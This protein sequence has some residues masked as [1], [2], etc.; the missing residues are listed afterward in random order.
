MPIYPVAED[1]V[2]LSSVRDEQLAV[3]FQRRG[4][5]HM[6]IWITEEI[7]PREVC[8]RSKLF[9]AVNINPLTCFQFHGSFFVDEGK[10]V[11][12]IFGRDMDEHDH[13]RY[14]A[15]VV[16]GK[17]GYLKKVDL[18]ESTFERGSPLMCSSYVPSSVQ[19]K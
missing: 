14:A 18:G 10:K 3:L 4:S 6:E 19:I 13:V 5:S 11:A 17:D 16:T 15:Y 9:V 7:E 2:S 1:T 12:V 8:W